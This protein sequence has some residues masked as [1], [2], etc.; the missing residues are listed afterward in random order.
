MFLSYET[1]LLVSK[2]LSTVGL[3]HTGMAAGVLDSEVNTDGK[4]QENSQ[5][6]PQKLLKLS[7]KHIR[8]FYV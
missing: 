5:D 6:Y 3:G 4:N 2:C 7:I 1:P 8:G